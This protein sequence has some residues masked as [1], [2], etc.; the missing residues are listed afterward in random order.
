VVV[1]ACGQLSRPRYPDIPGLDRFRGAAF[2]SA[3][4]D[5]GFDLRGARVAVIG[6]GASAVQIV[7]AIAPDTARLFVFQRSPSWLIPKPER[8][9]A[10]WE[11]WLHRRFP[12][13][14]ALRRLRVYAQFESRFP[15]FL[16][17]SLFAALFQKTAEKHLDEQIADPALRAAL[18]PDYPIGC[19]RVLLSSDYYPTLARDDVELVTAPIE[20]VTEDAI[21]TADGRARPV[22]AIVFATGF[23]TTEFLAPVSIAGR[24]GVRLADAWRGGASAYLGMAVHGFPNMFLLYGPNT[25]LGHNSIVFMVE[26]QVGYVVQCARALADG[27]YATMDVRPQAMARYRIELR[28]ALRRSVFAAD[29]HSWYKTDDGQVTNNWPSSTLRYWWYTRRLAPGDY[30]FA[31]QFAGQS[32]GQSAG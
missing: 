28:R 25:N 22:D 30:Y 13:I 2:H 23:A 10:A 6:S 5:H 12:H 14:A 27:G 7:P 18:R 32:A 29:C 11:R 19:K 3:R 26:R 24:D 31:G 1:W 17:G 4:W 9:F 20:R 16:H 21:V 8:A 15:A